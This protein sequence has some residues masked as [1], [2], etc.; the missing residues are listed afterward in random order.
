MS[1]AGYPVADAGDAGRPD[2]HLLD[3]Q[4]EVDELAQFLASWQR[5]TV[6]RLTGLAEQSEVLDHGLLAHVAE[7]ARCGPDRRQPR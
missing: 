4:H 5:V 3:R 7:L 6:A 2:A 1:D